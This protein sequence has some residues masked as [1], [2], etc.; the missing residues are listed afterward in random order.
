[1]NTNQKESSMLKTTAKTAVKPVRISRT[2]AIQ[3]LDGVKGRIVSLTCVR[4][5]NKTTTITGQIRRGNKPMTAMGY[6][7]VYDMV[8]HGMRNVNLQTLQSLKVNKQVY[9]VNK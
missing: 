6:L 3:L 4:K 9:Q 7:Q 8:K 5:D 2:K 1:M